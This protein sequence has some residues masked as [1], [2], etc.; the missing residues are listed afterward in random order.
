MSKENLRRAESLRSTAAKLLRLASELE[1]E[2]AKTGGGPDNLAYA[3]RKA[4]ERGW[5]AAELQDM[6]LQVVKIYQGRRRR[7]KYL[8][9]DLFGEPGWDILLDL[10]AAGLQ[11]RTISVTSACV[12]ADVPPTTA[13]R[14]IRLMEDHG[15]VERT[16]HV[17]DQRVSLLRLTDKAT[18]LMFI[19][20]DDLLGNKPVREARGL[21]L[22]HGL[23]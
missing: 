19:L 3:R 17:A 16:E 13:L 14:W 5:D 6:T 10:F 12:G 21:M 15:L 9:A 1:A 4:A 2:G 23:R 11:D 18:D 8:P 20:F 7:R 22:N